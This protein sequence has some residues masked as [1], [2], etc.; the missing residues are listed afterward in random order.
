MG[1]EDKQGVYIPLGFSMPKM[2]SA[3]AAPPVSPA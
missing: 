2:M 1:V 3:R